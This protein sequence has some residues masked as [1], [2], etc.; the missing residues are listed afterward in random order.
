MMKQLSFEALYVEK[1][2]QPIIFSF[3]VWRFQIECYA[4]REE[5]E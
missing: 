4:F 3:F 2:N 1:L 5:V